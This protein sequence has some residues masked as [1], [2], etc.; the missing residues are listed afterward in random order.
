MHYSILRPSLWFFLIY[1]IYICAMY[2]LWEYT[3]LIIYHWKF[4][5]T[6]MEVKIHQTAQDDKIK[7]IPSKSHIQR[8]HK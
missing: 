2:E 8:K 5:L 6:Y 3:A 4:L 1:Q 7:E